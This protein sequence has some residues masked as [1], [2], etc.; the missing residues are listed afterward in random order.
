LFPGIKKIE[1]VLAQLSKRVNAASMSQIKR[2][3]RKTSNRNHLL[4]IISGGVIMQ[5]FLTRSQFGKMQRCA[6]LAKN[7]HPVF[8]RRCITLPALA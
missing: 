7:L 4:Q 8:S 2:T 6:E 5:T 3:N 1:K